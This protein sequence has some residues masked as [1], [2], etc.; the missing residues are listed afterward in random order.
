MATSTLFKNTIA[1]NNVNPDLNVLSKTYD[2]LTIEERNYVLVN[3]KFVKNVIGKSNFQVLKKLSSIDFKKDIFIFMLALEEVKYVAWGK[4][5]ACFRFW[6]D[7]E[8][9]S[10]NSEEISKLYKL[11]KLEFKL[12]K[13]RV[14]DLQ[15]QI[16]PF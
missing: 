2:K 3:S 5:V 7:M 15:D 14:A 1:F 10:F 13:Q 9:N 12:N 11:A 8:I 4:E 16:L 6:L